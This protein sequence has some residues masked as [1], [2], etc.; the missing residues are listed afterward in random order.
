MKPRKKKEE[1]LETGAEENKGTKTVTLKS[2]PPI[3]EKKAEKA[4]EAGHRTVSA[5]VQRQQLAKLPESERREVLKTLPVE[6][7]EVLLEVPPDEVDG[8]LAI[9]PMNELVPD[10]RFPPAK[11]VDTREMKQQPLAA[12]VDAV[13]DLRECRYLYTAVQDGVRVN[14]TEQEKG[15]LLKQGAAHRSTIVKLQTRQADMKAALDDLKRDIQAQERERD[16]AID[17]SN[18]GYITR[19]CRTRYYLTPKGLVVEALEI[20]E[21][22][23]EISRPRYPHAE[24]DSKIENAKRG[25]LFGEE[26]GPVMEDDDASPSNDEAHDPDGE[27]DTDPLG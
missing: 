3:E 10:F 20:R 5:M 23:F 13:V 6:E 4:K 11:V 15:E 12:H 25:P 17:A 24:E 18:D 8:L 14:L 7:R 21:G 2:V 16:R 26:Q 1:A 9:R 27:D 22:V 19:D